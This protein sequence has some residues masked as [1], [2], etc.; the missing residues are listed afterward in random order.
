[1]FDGDFVNFDKDFPR[2]RIKGL[3]IAAKIART[4][5]PKVSR[6]DKVV[7]LG[8]GN[9]IVTA[10]ILKKILA[11]GVD[12]EDIEI[13]LVDSVQTVTQAP[14]LDHVRREHKRIQDYLKTE[15]PGSVDKVIMHS[16]T[17][18]GLAEKDYENLAAILTEG[19]IV[20]EFGD[21]FLKKALLEKAGFELVIAAPEEED[22][23]R[24][25]NNR[26][27]RKKPIGQHVVK[28][29]RSRD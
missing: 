17:S 1:M 11:E 10:A 21:T 14:E 6:E 3:E 13:N 4:N 5:L 25:S 16:V 28:R 22:D 9:G 24:I 2:L 23:N 8:A 12:I 15:S 20:Y 7:D 27:W 19:G 26:I 18:H 29:Q